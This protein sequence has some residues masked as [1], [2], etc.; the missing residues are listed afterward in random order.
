MLSTI[1]VIQKGEGLGLV[2]KV[3]IYGQVSPQGIQILS[4]RPSAVSGCVMHLWY[5]WLFIS[6]QHSIARSLCVHDVDKELVYKEE[7]QVTVIIIIRPDDCVCTKGV[8]YGN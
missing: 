4:D 2:S 1:A 5:P 6:N 3:C 7:I 8:F